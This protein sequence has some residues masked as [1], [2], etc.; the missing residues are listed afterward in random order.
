MTNWN[1]VLPKRI[2]VILF[3]VDTRVTSKSSLC[4]F[5]TF[6]FPILSFTNIRSWTDFLLEK[7]RGCL[8]PLIFL[9]HRKNIWFEAIYSINCKI[10]FDYLENKVVNQLFEQNFLQKHSFMRQK[11]CFIFSKTS[12]I[13][14]LW[15]TNNETI[16]ERWS[17][18]K[19][20]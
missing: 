13:S 17:F 7:W 19:N 18:S 9:H 10:E 14:I 6:F 11:C 4:M 1:C 3:V 16:F 12:V 15:K 8:S 20:E 5:T 2:Q